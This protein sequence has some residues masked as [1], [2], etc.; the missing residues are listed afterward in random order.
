MAIYIA[1][2]II[3]VYSL[4]TFRGICPGKEISH[5]YCVY[6]KHFLRMGVKSLSELIW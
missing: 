5:V 3:S 1:H 4:N 6:C 2:L